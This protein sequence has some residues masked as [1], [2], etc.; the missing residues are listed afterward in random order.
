MLRTEIVD[1]ATGETAIVGL[2]G[3]LATGPARPSKSF[4]AT[5]DIDDTPVE[6]VPASGGKTFCVTAVVLTGNKNI[7]PNVDAVVD[8]YTSTAS[9]S[10]IPVTTI[11]TIPVSRSAQTVLSGIILETEPG[12][13]VNGVTSDD[14]VLIT[15]LG[16]YI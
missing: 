4:N 2:G 10:T 11:L 8:I 6:I 12:H 5:L 14:D 1:P 9:A 15:M 7:D 16:F 13:F 3:A